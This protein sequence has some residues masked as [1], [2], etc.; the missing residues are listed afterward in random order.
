MRF[1][2]GLFA[3]SLTALV[4][5]LAFPASAQVIQYVNADATGANNGLTSL[6]DMLLIRR[7]R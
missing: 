4:L 5:C 7:A 1:R 2:K 6:S 3:P